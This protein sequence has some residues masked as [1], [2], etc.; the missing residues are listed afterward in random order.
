MRWLRIKAVNS[1]KD[2]SVQLAGL[3]IIGGQRLVSTVIHVC[4]TCRKLYRKL[5]EQKMADFPADRLSTEPLSLEFAVDVFGPWNVTS[6]HTRGDIA[7]A[8]VKSTV[9]RF[10]PVF[11]LEQFT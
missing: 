6:R 2:G 7:E 5:E 10:L 4:D 9:L 1:L 8:V 11:Q 3:W